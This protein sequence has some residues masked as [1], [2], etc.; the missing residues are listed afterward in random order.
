LRHTRTANIRDCFS[1]R[2]TFAFLHA[3]HHRNIATERNGLDSGF[4]QAEAV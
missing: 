1:Y 3:E 2:P 4:T